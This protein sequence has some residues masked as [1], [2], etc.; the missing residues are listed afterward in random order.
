MRLGELFRYKSRKGRDD[1]THTPRYLRY[2]HRSLSWGPRHSRIFT[3][4]SQLGAGQLQWG[5]SWNT[6]IFGRLVWQ[7]VLQNKDLQ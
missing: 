7:M 4:D 6:R 5:M 3:S 1:E 2:S